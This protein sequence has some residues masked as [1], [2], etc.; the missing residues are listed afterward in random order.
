MVKNTIHKSNKCAA[1]LLFEQFQ[2]WKMI[3]S[4]LSKIYLTSQNL[5]DLN[6]KFSIVYWHFNKIIL[7]LFHGIS[8]S[9]AILNQ[10]HILTISI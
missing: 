5:K 3:N 9:I 2:K 8:T 1:K 7:A 10:R 4:N 6:A